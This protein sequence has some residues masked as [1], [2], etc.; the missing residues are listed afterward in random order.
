MN[1]NKLS[2]ASITVEASLV[3]PIFIFAMYAF[4]F[5]LQVLNVQE[6]IQQGLLRT[7]RYCEKVGYVYDY[8]MDYEAEEKRYLSD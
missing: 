2:K 6:E 3:L 7:A 8:V 4:I 1:N 5:F